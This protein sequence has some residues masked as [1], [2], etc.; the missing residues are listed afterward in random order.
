MMTTEAATDT[1]IDLPLNYFAY[2]QNELGV[3]LNKIQKQAVTQTEGAVLLLA[4]PGSGK[5]T[6]LLMRIGY[7]VREL[8]VH[9]SRIKA[10]TFSR[11]SANEMKERFSRYFPG[12]HAQVQFSTIHSLCFEIVRE[13]Y[14]GEP[15]SFQIIEGSMDQAGVRS[16]SPD[17]PPLYKQAI[18]RH[19]YKSINGEPLTDDQMEELTTYISYVKN[20]MLSEDQWGAVKVSVAQ[21]ERVL[22]EYERF[23]RTSHSCLLVDYDD[24]LT[25][26][27][28]LLDRHPAL[29][30]AYQERYDYLLTDESQD[31]SLVQHELI[32]KLVKRHGNLF[33]VADDD[34]SI[35]SWRGAEP[36]YLL[37]FRDY[38]PSAEV[39]FMEQNYRSVPVI[40]NTADRFIRRNKQRY[41]KKMYTENEDEGTIHIHT[42]ADSRAQAAYLVEELRS[43]DSDQLAS[44]AILYRNNA[45]SIAM[46]HALDQA[47]IPFYIKDMDNRFFSHWVVEDIL[48]FMRMTFT[49]KRADLLHKIH[50]K[51]NGYISKQQMAELLSIDNQESVFDNLLRH[52][53][54]KDYQ[55]KPLEAVRDTL[56]EMKGM[57]PLPAIRVIRE[58]LGYDKGLDKLCEWQGHRKDNLNE[59]LGTLEE[60]AGTQESMEA[61]AARLKELEAALKTSKRH[62]QDQQLLTLSTFHSAKGLEFER[63]YMIDLMDGMIPSSEDIKAYSSGDE[64]RMEEAVRLFYVGMTRA[65]QQLELISCRERG[66]EKTGESRFVSHVRSLL[67]PEQAASSAEGSVNSPAIRPGDSIKHR[68]F[69]TGEVTGVNGDLVDIRF[70]QE[71]RTL[72]LRVCLEMGLLEVLSTE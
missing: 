21:A 61:F 65:K 23:K 57:P 40:V 3:S 31:T 18:L 2:I 4:S 24:M 60:I 41:D 15:D 63:V 50:L 34:Q 22:R 46:V 26:A 11:A 37:H 48:N 44:S 70:A 8:G 10:V 25:L 33:V 51:M 35:Y 1:I 30:S 47:A 38:Y 67:Q 16:A 58:R 12:Q 36:E 32:S 54:L 69:G 72:S 6:T 13:H 53:P 19:I 29:L 17:Q 20:K 43:L 39:L 28:D 71:L 52:V 14:R 9:P 49:D 62:R 68:S 55:I 59:I 45:S 27:N 5:T 64:S 7:L 56:R 66:G 42:A